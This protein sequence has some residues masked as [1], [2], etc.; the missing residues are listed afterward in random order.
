MINHVL[1]QKATIILWQVELI[2]KMLIHADATGVDSSDFA[3]QAYLASLKLNVD[4]LERVATDLISLKYR[5]DKV[6]IGK[7]KSTPV[8]LSKKSDVVK[9]VVKKT[10]YDELLKK[11]NAID[12]GGLV[13]KRDY[14]S[15]INEIQGKIPSVTCLATT[16]EKVRLPT[17]L[18][19]RL[20]LKLEWHN[21]KIRVEFKGSCLKQDKVI[22]TLNNA[23]N[24]FIAYGLDR[25]CQ[26]LKADFTL[27]DCLMR[28]VN[29]AK[30]LTL[31]NILIQGKLI[32]LVIPEN[33]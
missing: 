22:F 15:K 33:W 2:K 12:T 1:N 30:I 14:D 5:V 8:D 4:E 11:C 17:I 3:K 16:N 10:E 7:S 24:L 19:Y 9:N 28:A 27:K 13:Q 31:I 20:S 25:W 32:I 6:D 29:L 23:A 21:S 26:D 18:N